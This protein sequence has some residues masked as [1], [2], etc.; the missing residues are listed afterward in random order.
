MKNGGVGENNNVQTLVKV[1]FSMQDFYVP[2]YFHS[3][4]VV[5]LLK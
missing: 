3:V 1:T 5:L 4:E 2:E